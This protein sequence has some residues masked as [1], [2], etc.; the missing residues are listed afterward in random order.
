MTA[1]PDG[2]G[3]WP[4]SAA[5]TPCSPPS[6]A[7]RTAT[8]GSVWSPGDAFAGCGPSRRARVAAP[9]LRRD[10]GGSARP[11]DSRS[12]KLYSQE[13]YGLAARALTG[14]GRLAVHAGPSAPS[15]W[16]T[17][18]TLR[19]AGLRTAPYSVVGGRGCGRTRDWNLV[20]AASATPRLA[21]PRKPRPTSTCPRRPCARPPSRPSAPAP[22]TPSRPPPCSTRGRRARSGAG[23]ATGAGAATG[24][25][26]GSG[27]GSGTDRA[28]VTGSGRG[29]TVPAPTHRGPPGPPE[30]IAAAKKG[31]RR[32]VQVPSVLGRLRRMEHESFVPIPRRPAGGSPPH[33][34]HLGVRPARVAAGRRRRGRGPYREGAAPAAHRGLDDHVPRLGHPVGRR[35]A[36]HAGGAGHGGARRGG[37]P[38]ERPD[39]PERGGA[40]GAG[41]HGGLQRLGGVRR[42]HR[43]LRARGRG[44]RGPAPAGPFLRGVRRPRAERAGGWR[45]GSG[46][47]R[48]RDRIRPAARSRTRG[49]ARSR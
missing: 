10:R 33:A 26:C 30:V 16:T 49:R 13:F 9:A 14:G 29:P 15:L 47:F 43:V 5:S 1:V 37:D 41:Y 28:R 27:E 25:R 11:R 36:L 22:A 38:G 2:R 31:G 7:T 35:L 6:T 44:R 23:V 39:H 18:A 24:G 19:A 48:G 46:R 42:P 45:R 34:R 8:P 40:A 20:L 32:V 21:L 3:A 17:D 12:T 4:G